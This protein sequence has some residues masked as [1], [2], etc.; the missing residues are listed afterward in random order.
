MRKTLKM[1]LLNLGIVV[2]AVVCYADGLLGLR[3]TDPSLL[4]AGLSILAGL[5]LGAALIGGNYKLLQGRKPLKTT[6]LES[7]SQIESTLRSFTDSRYFGD[8]AKTGVDQ[9]ARLRQSA[10]R[11]NQAVHMKFQ[12]GSLSA[13]RYGGA[14]AAAE[15]AAVENMKTIALRM[16]VFSDAE[17][18][19]LLNYK[20]DDI[21][22]DIQEKQLGLY[23]KSLEFIRHSVS[24][25]ENLILKLDTLAFEM[26]DAAAKEDNG[27]DM[28]LDEIAN[29]T[30][31]LKYY[32]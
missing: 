23:N 22:D 17:Y 20:N 18:A 2:T 24:V 11:A 3:P 19:R 26:S 12:K 28:L 7:A 32:K 5:G 15:N 21:P 9:Y 14:V 4:K 8:L 13:T 29:L 30:E 16:S 27:T 31:E 6:Q 25:N 10:A 1:I